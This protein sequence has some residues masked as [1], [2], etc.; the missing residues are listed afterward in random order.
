LLSLNATKVHL[1]ANF[2]ADWTEESI[3]GLSAGLHAAGD[4]WIE[5]FRAGRVF[6][7]EPFHAKILS[8]LKGGM[9]CPPRCLLGGCEWTITPQGHIYPC[10]QMVNEDTRADLR[11]GHIERGIDLAALLKMRQAKDRVEKTCAECELRDRCQSHCGCRHVA[12]SGELG[13]IT[14]TL[15]EIEAA[16]IAE[17]DRVAETL[18]AEGCESFI[19]YY[20]KRNW[21]PVRGGEMWEQR[22]AREP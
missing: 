12:L 8:H 15:C 1:A 20:Y 16:H 14:A 3:Q 22:R 21:L 10:A 18:Y 13:V 7:V 5:H 17:A 19:E 4:V 11:I 2:A 6:A 9:P